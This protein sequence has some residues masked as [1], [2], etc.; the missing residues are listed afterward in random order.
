MPDRPLH[1]GIGVGVLWAGD[2]AALANTAGGVIVL[3]VAED[4]Q[5]RT[6]DAPGVQ[7]TDGHLQPMG[8]IDTLGTQV[9]TAQPLA[10]EVVAP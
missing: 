7:V 10:A 8:F 5:A 1:P 6:V 9:L 4:D 2:V 3:G